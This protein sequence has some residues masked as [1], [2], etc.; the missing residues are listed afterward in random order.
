MV[1]TIHLNKTE[2]EPSCLVL[3]WMD[4]DLNAIPQV[5]MRADPKYP[6][7]VFKGVLSALELLRTIDAVHTGAD[8]VS[9]SNNT[10]LTYVDINPNNIYI[11]DIHGDNPVAKLG[12][13]GAG[14]HI[15]VSLLAV[16]YLLLQRSQ[17]VR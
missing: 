1:D 6:R 9:P 11:S 3:E 16:K 4:H 8:V 7:A 10:I 2:E 15:Y 5:D 17:T 13:L 14:K 12:D